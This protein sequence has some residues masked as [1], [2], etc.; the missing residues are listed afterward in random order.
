[1]LKHKNRNYACVYLGKFNGGSKIICSYLYII[2]MSKKTQALP[3]PSKASSDVPF[4]KVARTDRSDTEQI[5]EREGNLRKYV[6]DLINYAKTKGYEPLPE[7][8]PFAF[9]GDVTIESLMAME[10]YYRDN[11][12]VPY[13]NKKKG[14]RSRRKS[15]RN[16]RRRSS[17]KSF[18]GLF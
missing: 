11:Y 17:R 15:R 2:L 6:N 7:Q 12:E 4:L 3:V 1:M 8:L 14:G 9:R 13:R 16:K 18:F 10:A 5:I